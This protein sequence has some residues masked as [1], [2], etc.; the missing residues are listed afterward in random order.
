M[1]IGENAFAHQLVRSAIWPAANDPLRP[2]LRNS[3]QINELVFGGGVDINKACSRFAVGLHP[4]LDAGDNGSH[5]TL[6]ICSSYFGISRGLLRTLLRLL[7]GLRGLLLELLIGWLLSIAGR[8]PKCRSYS[9]SR[10]SD[11]KS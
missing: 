3:R 2:G 1:L 9:E 7:G 10:K 8:E 4:F 6:R 5:L 11:C